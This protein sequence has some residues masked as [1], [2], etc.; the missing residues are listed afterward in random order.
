MFLY[1]RPVF[2]ITHFSFKLSPESSQTLL[3][4]RAVV[5]HSYSKCLCM[6]S[7]LL[8]LDIIFLPSDLVICTWHWICSASLVLHWICSDAVVKFKFMSMEEN[9]V[10]KQHTKKLKRVGSSVSKENKYMVCT[11]WHHS[12]F[13]YR[14]DHTIYSVLPGWCLSWTYLN[15]TALLAFGNWIANS[16]Q[17]EMALKIIL[18]STPVWQV[19]EE[20]EWLPNSTRAGSEPCP[21][22]SLL[23]SAWGV[24]LREKSYRTLWLC[25]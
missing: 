15:Y 25:N 4:L 21:C 7:G 24:L 22:T 8:S 18:F 12:H 14:L 3:G 6:E 13:S 9:V 20:A 16:F 11:W 2:I 1:N 10:L 5:L 19:R 17:N 23:L